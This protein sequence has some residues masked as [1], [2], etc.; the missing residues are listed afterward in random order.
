MEK[1]P[2]TKNMKWPKSVVTIVIISKHGLRWI[3]EKFGDL[4]NKTVGKTRIFLHFSLQKT[5]TKYAVTHT[6]QTARLREDLRCKREFLPNSQ[7]KQ[8]QE[9]LCPMLKAILSKSMYLHIRNSYFDTT[10][11]LNGSL[12]QQIIVVSSLSTLFGW[13]LLSNC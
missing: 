10:Y 12:R 1:M 5:A 2:L 13:L 7:S 4:A 8:I 6:Q 11:D 3:I 9:L